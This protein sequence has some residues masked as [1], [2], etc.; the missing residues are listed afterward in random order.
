MSNSPARP[1]PA[2]RPGSFENPHWTRSRC[3]SRIVFGEHV[4]SDPSIS[5]QIGTPDR[6]GDLA[7]WNASMFQPFLMR[8]NQR[9]ILITAYF[10][11]TAFCRCRGRRRDVGESNWK[12]F[13]RSF[14]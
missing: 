5:R 9:P 7:G 8:P 11:K 4:T 3:E 13:D 6:I 2:E 14:L 1:E 12:R 10:A